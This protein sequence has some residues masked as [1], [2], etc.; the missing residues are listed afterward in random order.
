MSVQWFPG[1]MTKAIRQIESLLPSVD[2]IIECRD[3]RIVASS[4]NPII[5][6]FIAHKPRLMV[7]TKKDLADSKITQH[8][9]DYFQEHEK[10]AVAVDNHKDN[11]RQLL[12]QKV[13]QAMAP[14]FERQRRRGIKPRKVRAMIC[15]VPNVGKSTIINRLAKR[16]V[17]DVQNRP[18]VTMALTRINI[19]KDLEIVDSPGLL[20]PKFESELQG[21][22]LALCASVKTTGF[23]MK[24]VLREGFQRLLEVRPQ[25]LFDR[26]SFSFN[27]YDELLNH[28]LE[29]SA[30][31]EGEI[32]N[33][34]Y[35][36]IITH[37]F[38]PM[39][40]EDVE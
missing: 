12:D 13:K 8:W 7:L 4:R 37:Q 16:K 40:W 27:S 10:L 24:V 29:T 6:N 18:G 26:Y 20:W 19:S 3:A 1:H 28:L 5:E 39:S 22:H 21:I 38:G 35:H 25:A 9:L 15:G 11:I 36:D 30:Q 14:V 2:M 23:D 34:L 17:V 31:T 32:E 33:R